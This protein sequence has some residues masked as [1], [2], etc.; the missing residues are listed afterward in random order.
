MVS[1]LALRYRR[2]VFALVGALMLIGGVSYFSLPARED[3]Q[4][5][6]REAVVT[7]RFPGQTPDRMERL[8]TRPIERAARRLKE[9]DEITSS[10]LP[11]LS[12]VHVEVG[13]TYDDLDQIWDDLRD[14]IE[15]ARGDLPAGAQ[16]PVV[17][18]DVGDVAVATMA[19][20]GDGYTMGEMGEMADHLSDRLYGV[21]G[22]KRVA[23]YGE[24]PEAVEVTLDEA[25]LATLGLAPGRIVA[26]L[27]ERNTVTPG[28]QIDAGA[29][30]LLVEPTGDFEDVGRIGDTLIGLPGGGTLALR[31]VAE[32]RRVPIDSPPERAYVNGERAIVLGV[33]MLDGVRVLEFAPRLAARMDELA[34]GLPVGYRLERVTWQAD[35]VAQSVFGVTTNV[36]QTIVL[37][38]VVVVLMLGLR[39]GLIVG[40]IV[41][42]VMLA[43][44]ALFATAGVSLERMSLA[45]LIIALGL[46]VDNGI[47]V[48]EDFRERLAEGK[49][50]DEALEG[51]GR[52]LTMPLLSST[53]TTILV[54][55]PLM[56]APSTAGEYTRSISIVVAL[57]L[58]LS[59]AMAMT[60]TPVLCHRFLRA[61]EPG[62]RRPLNDRMFD[63]LRSGY[64]MALAWVL[65]HR[66]A[67]LVATALALA[68][69]VA[70]IAT[71]PSKFFP[72][73]DRAQL[74]TY[75]D[76]QAGVTSD[77]T[78]ALMRRVTA[79]LQDARFDWMV[80]NATYVGFGGPRF[81]LSLTPVDPAPNRAVMITDVRDAA[82]MDRAIA[83]MRAHFRDRYPEMRAVV[84][85]MFFGPS[86]SNVVEVRLSGPDADYLYG[87]A[88]RVEAILKA[89]PGAHDV[90][91]D[92]ENRV[93]R[94]MVEVDQARAAAAG[95][96]SAA[97]AEALARNVSGLAVSEF[98]DGDE[99]IPILARGAA[100]VRADPSRLE[101]LP[102]FTPAGVA[103]P[104]G[105]VARVR[106]A[107]G[108]ARMERADLS[109]AITVEG[110]SSAMAAEGI[111][112]FIADD[113]ASLEADLP[114]G[115]SVEVVGVVKESAE[116][117]AS[118][119][120]NMPL[121]FGL[122]ALLLVAQFNSFRRAGV[123][124]MTL[125][126]VI[127]GVA[128]GLHVMGAP[129]GFMPIL[130]I[131]SLFGIILNNG[132]VLIDRIDIERAQGTDPA[133]AVLEASVRRLRPIVMTTVT[134]VLGLLPLIV[135]GDA[136][137]YGF[138]SVVAWGLVVGTVLTLG[139]VPALYA[140]VIGVGRTDRDTGD[141]EPEAEADLVEAE[142][143]AAD[144]PGPRIHPLAAE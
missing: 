15:V 113:L 5:T 69:G 8:V 48:A 34:A 36:A 31:D 46:F 126:L 42:T 28:G 3:P 22:V 33:S 92:W 139:V 111:A 137:F 112:P 39:T 72:D 119:A 61:P 52:E 19:L 91:N 117:G 26:A 70:G 4:I 74:V 136:L 62:A 10:S 116:S 24:V 96:T 58:G 49:S 84:T 77:T 2:L 107:N 66:T 104:L 115:H 64:R 105:Q 14:E 121:C 97:I 98:R 75:I 110:R 109:R 59:W 35:A 131:L 56:L 67:F 94:L 7:V 118:L 30:A 60:L 82:D 83:D 1:V 9:V 32:V 76:L 99:V 140:L 73:S 134:T 122:V 78:D 144:A 87:A 65:R 55:L 44:I 53:L 81:V 47:V 13:E 17:R 16:A 125:P 124:L 129:F 41:P 11:G 128:I 90:S 88:Q 120:A 135:S 130:G 18:D 27:S 40:A 43:T 108:F 103:V 38:L 141:G 71:A 143:E 54:F 132:I 80:T 68:G 133:T 142:A 29:G 85:R 79:S 57:S 86:D 95:V 114:P 93:P 89:V 25:R 23:I 12:I 45:T 101:T 20:V 102:V 106:I 138:A 51:V 37:V 123:V 21:A 100:A 50:H 63:P 127:V 6:I